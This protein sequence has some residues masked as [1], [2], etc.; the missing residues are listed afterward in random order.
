MKFTSPLARAQQLA[1]VQ[2]IDTYL[3]ATMALDAV[4]DPTSVD[5]VDVP[6]LNR[7]RAERLGVPREG[8]RQQAE[9]EQLQAARQKAQAAQEAEQAG[10]MAEQAKDAGQPTTAAGLAASGG[11]RMRVAAGQ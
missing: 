4:I 10:L 1:D 8:M 9:I 3:N 5:N 7:I 2:A 11:A 6:K